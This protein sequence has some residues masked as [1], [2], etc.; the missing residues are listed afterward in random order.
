[1]EFSSQDELVLL[2]LLIAVTA[3]TALAPALRVPYPI[4]LV[5]GGL[6]LGFI[7]GVP[8]VSL[9]PELVLVGVLPPLLYAAS[10]FT[11]LRD[12]RA[13]LKPIGLLAIGLVVATMLGVAA[14]AHLATGLSWPAS[15]VLGAVV[16]PTDPIAATAIARRFG[17]PRRIVTIV[18]GESLVND[19]TALVLYGVAVTAVVTGSF[20]LLEGGLD[21]VVSVIG[22]I[23]VG[24]AVGW[25]VAL[26]RIRLDNIPAEIAISLLTGF[27][28]YIPA[29]AL[30]VSGVLAA[31][32][33]GFY[34][35][36]RSPELS[37]PAMRLQ[38][39]AVWET[40]VFL[41]NALLFTLIGLQLGP[42]LDELRGETTGDLIID[43]LVVTATVMLV[44][45]VWV[46]VL[47]P[48]DYPAVI[49]WMGMRGAVSLAAALALPLETD[50]GAPF[51]GRE[52]IIFLAFM[53]I[54]GTLVGQGLTL[55]KLIH[56]LDLE[57]DRL[58]AKEDTKARIYAA[59]AALQR[60][61][62]LLD[63]DWVR[64]ET[65]DRLRGLYNFRRSRFQARF[66]GEDD[67]S[68]E[69]QSTDFQRLRRELLE[70]E[71]AA[72]VGL[73]RQGRISD[74]VMRRVERDLDLEDSRLEI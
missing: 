65:A 31:V 61:E 25:I 43:A 51:P 40:L 37:T 12:F 67:G 49:G 10:F 4:L 59:D 66:D 46:F 73:R 41:L 8:E 6:A 30:G 33:V 35:G 69:R 23:A 71:R 63:E 45:I 38:A 16:A 44:R 42:I 34:L 17:V 53:V 72:I 13:N 5:L 9:P 26:V 60:L 50:A 24:L 57:E 1:M 19:A 18:E 47:G 74:E 32:T 68:I 14:V 21:F 54:L 52:L 48:R 22:G 7:P 64:P 11:S 15:F 36:W 70:A 55:P 39:I 29:Q 56:W 20:S 62:E 28:A 27:L 2:A 3:L 58:E